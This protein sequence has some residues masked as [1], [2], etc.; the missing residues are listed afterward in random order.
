MSYSL[1]LSII[2][3]Q[4]AVLRGDFETAN[5]ILPSIPQE[6]RNR[7][8]HFLDAQGLKEQA[9][10]VSTDPDH[11]FEL[12]LQVQIF[13]LYYVCSVLMSI[14]H[15]LGKLELAHEIAK[16]DNSEA[17]RKQLADLSFNMTPLRVRV[18]C[19]IHETDLSIAAGLD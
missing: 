2:N 3:Y 11:R 4:T 8:A 14:V 19:T 17:K 10:D 18:V 16:E 7:V 13:I 9:L 15:Q 1:H 12:A 5:K 6:Q